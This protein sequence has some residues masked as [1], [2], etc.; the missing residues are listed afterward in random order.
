MSH[1][2]NESCWPVALKYIFKKF[3]KQIKINKKQTNCGVLFVDFAKAFD[4]IDHDLL[5][6]NL[7]VY[8][9]SP[10]TLTIWLSGLHYFLQIESKLCMW[11]H[12]H[13]MY[14][15]SNMEFPK[16]LFLNHYSFQFTLMTFIY[17]SSHVVNCSR[18]TQQ[19]IAV[20]LICKSYPSHYSLLQWAEF[21]H[22]SLHPDKTKFMYLS[23]FPPAPYLKKRKV[24]HVYIFN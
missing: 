23:L 6:R 22:K 1:C 18:M 21:N 24:H 7:V 12:L 16:V 5:L 14:H 4:V 11:M 8:G 20:T 3:T 9:L 10:E 17:S 19:S 13:P 15:I 2:F